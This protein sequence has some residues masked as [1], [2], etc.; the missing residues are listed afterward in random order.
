MFTVFIMQTDSKYIKKS[1]EEATVQSQK[2]MEVRKAGIN[3]LTKHSIYPDCFCYIQIDQGRIEKYAILNK[4][5]LNIYCIY[6]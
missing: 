4:A 1:N 2:N 6:C 5:N 3:S